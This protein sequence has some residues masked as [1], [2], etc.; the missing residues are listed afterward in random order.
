MRTSGGKYGGKKVVAGE[1][2]K[3][4]EANA[5]KT[6]AAAAEEAAPAAEE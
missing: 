3:N 6:P 2:A 1:K 4:V 5:V